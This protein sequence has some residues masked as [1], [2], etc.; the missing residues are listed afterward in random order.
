MRA[1]LIGVGMVAVIVLGFIVFLRKMVESPVVIETTAEVV[2]PS[3]YIEY[4]PAALETTSNNRRV[5]FFYANWCS[6]CR[7]ADAAFRTNSNQIP[8]DAV[9]IRVNY[10]DSETDTFEKDLARK[11]GITYQH[12]FV[13]VDSVGNEI[14]KWN[15]G[16]MAELLENIH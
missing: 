3:R 12:T 10:N 11:Y 16:Q 6:T 2:Q 9:V 15:G 8:G 4:S 5:L 14:T 7:L 13:Q 1:V